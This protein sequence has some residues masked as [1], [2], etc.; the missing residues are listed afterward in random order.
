[1]VSI[2]YLSYFDSKIVKQYLYAFGFSIIG[3]L[4]NFYFFRQVFHHIGEDSFYYYAYSRRIISFASPVLLLGLGVSL[5]R[6]MGLYGSDEAK[7]QRLF[8]A[9]M[10]FIALVSLVWVGLN[11]VF[12]NWFSKLLWGEVNPFTQKLSLALSFFLLGTNVSAIVHAFFR[13]KIN[14]LMS[15]VVELLVQSLI[16]LL[17]FVIFSNLVQIY[18]VISVCIIVFNVLVLMVMLKHFNVSINDFFRI[19][20]LKEL[21]DYGVRRVPGDFYYAMITFL[22]AFLAS[23]FFGVEFAGII[24]FGLSLLTLF[25]LPATAV[26]FVTL[27]RSA[28]LL[29]SDKQRL[30]K[31]TYLLLSL[32]LIYSFAVLVFCYFF[33]DTLLTLFFDSSFTK[34][35]DSLFV[36]LLALP[37]LVAFTVYRSITDSAYKRSYNSLFMFLALLCFA[38]FATLAKYYNQPNFILYGNIMVYVILAILSFTLSLRIFK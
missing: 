9:T 21:L 11:L 35:F 18:S 32:A 34:H 15:G 37:M 4:I 29:S 7:Q 36:L 20:E 25:N 30:R 3:A 17:A 14:A 24:S 33:L 8:L 13:G 38:L 6:A 12:N 2:K 26:S 19:Y 27:S 22:P 28:Q 1:M 23:R 31:E 16:P 10:L 5:P